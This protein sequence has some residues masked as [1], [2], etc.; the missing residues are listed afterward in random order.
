MP[1]PAEL[2]LKKGIP[3]TLMRNLH[4]KDGMCNGSRMVITGLHYYGIEA[5]LFGGELDGQPQ[6][7]FRASLPM[8]ND[9]EFPLRLTQRKF[10]IGVFFAMTVNKLQGRS[11]GVF[12]CILFQA[13]STLW[14]VVSSHRCFPTRI[15]VQET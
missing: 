11:L 3:V 10:P 2:L 4:D 13:R 1:P 15:T 8:T 14:C 9:G 7:L 12:D 6:I 5:H